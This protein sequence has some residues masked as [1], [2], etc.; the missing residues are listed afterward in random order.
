MATPPGPSKPNNIDEEGTEDYSSPRKNRLRRKWM[1]GNGLNTSWPSP[2]YEPNPSCLCDTCEKNYNI[3]KTSSCDSLPGSFT[4]T[5]D[6]DL[7]DGIVDGSKKDVN[8]VASCVSLND[9]ESRNTTSITVE[10]D[11]GETTL[12]NDEVNIEEANNFTTLS[13][14]TSDKEEPDEISKK[15]GNMGLNN[16]KRKSTEPT[17]GEK[18]SDTGTNDGTN[19]SY[20]ISPLKSFSKSESLSGAN[21]ITL[22]NRKEI[23]DVD[24]KNGEA[25]FLESLKLIDENDKLNTESLSMKSGK[26]KHNAS[27]KFINTNGEGGRAF[28]DK[29]ESDEK[30]ISERDLTYYE[31]NEK[32]S[33]DQSLEETC[34]EN[35][36]DYF[37]S[38]P[39][40]CFDEIDNSHGLGTDDKENLEKAKLE[41]AIRHPS[42]DRENRME[43]DKLSGAGHQCR[44]C[45]NNVL[46]HFRKQIGERKRSDTYALEGVEVAEDEIPYKKKETVTNS[47]DKEYPGAISVNESASQDSTTP[48]SNICTA[49]SLPMGQ[50]ERTRQRHGEG[51]ENSHRI[52]RFYRNLTFNTRR[53]NCNCRHQAFCRRLQTIVTRHQNILNS[54]GSVRRPLESLLRR[55]SRGLRAALRRCYPQNRRSLRALT[56]GGVDDI[57]IETPEGEVIFRYIGAIRLLL[58]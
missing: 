6:E 7:T 57:G 38:N 2:I 56:F 30:V 41:K 52:V 26:D 29:K 21:V 51:Q 13:N 18:S 10:K 34:A 24:H 9:E 39:D 17:G 47:A 20:R 31:K 23:N 28:S 37:K 8:F 4:D 48:D 11:I 53:G 54:G 5:H 16:I 55:N 43:K 12:V 22:E 35:G 19:D 15:N 44:I 33:L 14:T 27:G 49:T 50:L 42:V 1:R 25:V 58:G 46:Y 32:V 40:A 36:Y 3:Q 45:G